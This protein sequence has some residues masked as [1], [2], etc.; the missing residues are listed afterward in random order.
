MNGPPVYPVAGLR[1]P[2]SRFRNP[3][4]VIAG[5][6]GAA[7]LGAV[8]ISVAVARRSLL[9]PAAPVPS[10]LRDGQPGGALIGLVQVAVCAGAAAI[11]IAAGLQRRLRLLAGLA[12][13]GAVAAGAAAGILAL[14]G[15]GAPHALAARL[16]QRSWVAGAAFPDPALAAAAVAVCI[17][18]VPWLGQGWRR[19]AWIVVLGAGA[20]RLLT[21]TALPMELA[22]AAAAGVVAGLGVRVAA[23]VPDQRLGPDAIAAELRSADLPVSSVSPAGVRA[24][25]SRPFTAV[26][27][28]GRKLFIKAYGADRRQA[29]LLYRAYRAVRLKNVGDAR[30]AA[31]LQQAVEHQALLAVMAQRAGADVPRVHRVVR[32]A[33]GTMLLV[34]EQIDGSSLDQLPESQISD[35]VLDQLWTAVRTLHG[36]RLAHRSL[37][38]ANVMVDQSGRPWLVDFSFGELAAYQRQMDLDVAELLASLATL[39]GPD[40]AVSSAGDVIGTGNLAAAVPL[41]QPMA[42]SAATRRAIAG[43]QG[44][45]ARTRSAAAT[46]AGRPDADLASVQRVRPRTLL[47]VAVAAAAFYILLPKLAQAAGSWRAVLTADWVWVSVVIAA[48]A[49]TYVAS[50]LALTGSVPIRLRFWPTLTTQAASSFINRI[51]L[52][53]VGGMALNVRFL[54][55]SG[56]EPG[57]AVAA[58]AV[59]ALVGAVV[60][61]A[62]IAI[63]FTLASRRL[64]GAFKLPSASKLLL[65]LAVAAA[66]VGLVLASRPGRRFAARKVVP[67]ILSSLA[68]LRQVARRPVK[69]SLLVGGSALVTLAYIGGLAASVMAFA[70]HASIAE[71][72]A[73]Y[74]AAAAIAAASATPGGVGTFEAALVVGLTGIGIR[75]GVAVP[76]VLTYRLATY[77]LPVVPGWAAL[78]LLQRR[79]LV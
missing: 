19:A 77:W 53:N 32:T 69:I 30:P 3:R 50:A 76:A 17:A 70:A 28:D 20:A 47:G 40:R 59:N 1:L 31:S 22:I 57:G 64:A 35:D 73:V 55:K 38:A 58:V 68:N 66:V 9:G 51:S 52:A 11:L 54:Q 26:T 37:R 78:Q 5:I 75:S 18:M 10:L 67:G 62:L 74:L 27:D 61:L 65:I 42:L 23:G 29:D 34:M 48:S 44:L 2:P 63:F 16:A 46:A 25:G 6:G 15:D 4:D 72:G 33:E 8:L 39:V 56:V 60:H 24:K 41:L 12:A 36:A 49:L 13:A 21:G 79:N 45:L 14:A 7:L 43:H 71:I